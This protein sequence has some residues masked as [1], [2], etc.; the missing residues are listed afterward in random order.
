[1]AGWE[2]VIDICA[3]SRNANVN[4][5][6]DGAR[7]RTPLMYA[8]ATQQIGAIE[9]LLQSK[10]DPNLGDSEGVTALMWACAARVIFT[11]A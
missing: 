7:R 6:L 9:V 5:E 10:A 1:M 11:G 8:A 3:K 2:D 4:S